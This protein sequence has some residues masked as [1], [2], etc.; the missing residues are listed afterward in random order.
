MESWGKAFWTRGVNRDRDRER[1]GL[2]PRGN[3]AVP[4]TEVTPTTFFTV[5]Y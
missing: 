3:Q 2:P 5:D 1:A 4:I